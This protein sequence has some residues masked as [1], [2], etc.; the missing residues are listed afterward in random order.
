MLFRA[1][2]DGSD[3]PASRAGAAWPW[4]LWRSPP[5]CSPADRGPDDYR[6][7]CARSPIQACV[8]NHGCHGVCAGGVRAR[9]V[10]APRSGGG[11][12]GCRVVGDDRAGP[13]T[14]PCCPRRCTGRSENHRRIQRTTKS[15]QPTG[16]SRDSGPGCL[17]LGLRSDLTV[18]DRV[19]LTLHVCGQ[20]YPFRSAGHQPAY[21]VLAA[22][23][24]QTGPMFRPG[25]HAR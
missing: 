5:W 6:A 13:R 15:T 21:A 14:D 2:D 16:P 23:R 22:R 19:Q 25:R 11:F 9:Q 17:V 1:T 12:V 8:G 24:A 20:A 7:Q 4:A 10:P 18:T 3:D